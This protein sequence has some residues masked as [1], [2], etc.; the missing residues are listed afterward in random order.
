MIPST[1]RTRRIAVVGGGIT[2]L[3]AAYR[4]LELDE[5]V[6]VRLFEAGERLGGVLLSEHRDGFLLEHSADNFITTMPWATDLCR[7]LGMT[8]ELLSTDENRRKAYVVHHGRLVHVPEGFLLMAP[9]QIGPVLRT[10]LLSVGGKL[11][12]LAEAL[13]PRRRETGDES[14]ASF[15]RRRLGT[16]AYQKLVQPLV[17]G[18]YTADAEKLSIQ[19]ALPRFVKMEQTHGSLIRAMLKAARRGDSASDSGAR[20]GLFV[21][22]RDGMSSLVERLAEAIQGTGRATISLR[23]PVHEVRQTDGGWRVSIAGAGAEQVDS[24]VVALPAPHAAKL[25]EQVDAAL[26]A[27]LSAIP[28]AGCAIALA[29]FRRE[30]I[31]HPL[32][33]FGV[34][35]P[36]IEGRQILAASFSSLKFPGR[37]PDGCVLVRVFVGGA[38]R[39]ELIDLP[40]DALRELVLRELGELLGVGGE[41]LLFQV[42]RWHNAMPQYHLGHV[43]RVARI[44]ARVAELAGLELAGN[45]YRGVGV[46]DCIHSGEQAAERLLGEAH[47]DGAGE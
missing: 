21:A 23:C 12:L 10:P 9:R 33:G 29:A 38:K 4:L 46:P 15:A 26:A 45:A 42:R 43:D 13:V 22:P 44:E 27:E 20:Y 11:R 18:I 3:A 35:V 37:A 41:P 36:E 8:E 28:Y 7:R 40:D 16:E 1:A 17:G 31:A 19:A 39:P 34:V 32:D 14:L 47:A 25:L 24:V 2:G 5:H 30:Q 6:H